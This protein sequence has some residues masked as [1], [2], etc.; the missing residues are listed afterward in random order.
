MCLRGRSGGCCPP[1][2]HK[3][4]STSCDTPRPNPTLRC[5]GEALAEGAIAGYELQTSW[6]MRSVDV[7][8]KILGFHGGDYEE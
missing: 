4:V 2:G 7:L 3:A 8:C 1:F 5:Q 6:W